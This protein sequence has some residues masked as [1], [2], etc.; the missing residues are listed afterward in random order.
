M[1][2]NWPWWYAR[3]TLFCFR[4]TSILSRFLQRE[5]SGLHI[6]LQREHDIGR[7][8]QVSYKTCQLRSLVLLLNACN[9]TKTCFVT[10]SLVGSQGLRHSWKVVYF[11]AC[12][13]PSSGIQIDS[14]KLEPPVGLVDILKHRNWSGCGGH[15]FSSVEEIT[16]GQIT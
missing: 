10:R 7:A 3:E 1:N 11:K 2:F 12:S 13:H 8:A 16:P 15:P 14:L 4:E 6:P 5:P 9:L